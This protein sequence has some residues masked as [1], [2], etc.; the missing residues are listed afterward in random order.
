MT[1]TQVPRRGGDKKDNGGAVSGYVLGETGCE[2]CDYKTAT[3]EEPEIHNCEEHNY[4]YDYCDFTTNNASLILV[5]T[6]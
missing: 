1:V 6:Q 5:I 4:T 3:E 2:V